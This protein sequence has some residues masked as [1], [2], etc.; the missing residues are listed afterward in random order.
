[1]LCVWTDSTTPARRRYVNAALTIALITVYFVVMPI[2][3]FLISTVV[4]LFLQFCLLG[5]R[6]HWNIRLF[7]V[8][9]V[10][11]PVVVYF[12]FRLAFELRLPAGL[13]G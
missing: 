4:Y 5:E 9:A 2:V 3:G 6:R 10:I 1:M 7:A 11:I 8:L 12:T 13:I